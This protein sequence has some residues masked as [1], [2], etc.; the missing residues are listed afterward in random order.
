MTDESER[1]QTSD[2]LS[3]VLNELTIDQMRFVVNRLEHTTD[4]DAAIATGVSPSTVK[5]WKYKGAPIDEAVRLMAQDGLIIAQHI[6]RK[7]LA[8]AMLVKVAGLDISDE[9]LKQMV[10]TEI[11]EWEM[12]KAKQ[13]QE[14][15][16]ADGEPFRV[17]MD[18]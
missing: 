13:T 18:R 15:T 3:A 6:R 9:R 16:G 5:D 4:K 12:G 2:A 7:N 17:I 11:I 1:E 14:I 10:A 8:K